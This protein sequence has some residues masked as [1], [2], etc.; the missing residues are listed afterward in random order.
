MAK[1]SQAT[2]PMAK[3]QVVMKRKDKDGDGESQYKGR[4]HLTLINRYIKVID[5]ERMCMFDLLQ[6]PNTDSEAI[7]GLAL[8]RLMSDASFKLHILCFDNSAKKSFV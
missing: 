3:V 4:F 7:N 6:E 8:V 1:Q 2:F 5:I